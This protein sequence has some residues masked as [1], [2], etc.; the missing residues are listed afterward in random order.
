RAT[1]RP[2]WMKRLA[3]DDRRTPLVLA[4]LRRRNGRAR[5]PDA[6]PTAA[7]DVDVDGV[8]RRNLPRVA[9]P[10]LQRC[11]HLQRMVDRLGER[12]LHRMRLWMG[13]RETMVDRYWLVGVP[14]DGDAAAHV[15]R[16]VPEDA[17]H[18]RLLRR[19]R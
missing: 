1:L 18:E 7:G 16:L 2:S 11:A 5:Q 12:R 3:R 14:G 17:M 4:R 10:Y 8:V 6:H 19:R 9:E 15:A 13:I